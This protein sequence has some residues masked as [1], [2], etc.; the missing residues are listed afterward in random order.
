MAIRPTGQ[1][2]SKNK[3][4]KKAK[5]RGKENR[6]AK[7][8]TFNLVTPPI[9]PVTQHGKTYHPKSKARQ[10]LTGFLLGRTFKVNQGDLN[11]VNT[12]THRSF[13]F[14]VGEV[15]G[16]DCLGF[17][18]GM[19]L[20][21]DRL[22]NIIRKWHSLID[23]QL[24]VATSDGSQ[25]RVFVHAVTKRLPGQVKKNSYCQTTEAKKIRR[26]IFETIADE[27]EGI[28]VDKLVTKLASEGVNKEIEEKCAKIYPVT[29]VISKVKPIKNMKIIEALKPATKNVSESNQF[30][31]SEGAQ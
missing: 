17:F 4:S 15:R 12:E 1:Y 28:D 14:K 9:F 18:N 3:G 26:I 19:Q 20:A 21:R 30:V 11:G 23:A 24:T 27:L 13:C 2:V 31:V 7:K 6:F 5:S 16:N 25:W 22:A 10:D 8:Q 29:A